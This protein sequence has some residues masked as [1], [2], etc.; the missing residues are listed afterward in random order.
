MNGVLFGVKAVAH[1]YNEALQSYGS[2]RAAIDLDVMYRNRLHCRGYVL[3][4]HVSA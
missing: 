2:L 1:R 3:Y 4:R